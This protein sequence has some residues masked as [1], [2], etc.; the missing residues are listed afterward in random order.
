[1]SAFDEEQAAVDLIVAARERVGQEASAMEVWS[2][3]QHTIGPD[4]AFSLH[5]KCYEMCYEGVADVRPTWVPSEESIGKSNIQKMM[6][7]KGFTTFQEFYD[8]SIGPESRDDFWMSSMENCGIAWEQIPSKAF[9][10]S[11]GGVPNASY[12]PDGRLNIADSCFNKRESF[13]P[14]L[15]YAMESDPR[16]LQ[17]MSFA[18]LDRLSNQI[19]NALHD[20]LGLSPGDAIGICMP[21]TPESI[22]IYLG[23]VKS[24][25]VVISIADSFSAA[26]IAMRCRLGNAKA[27]ITQDVIYRGA[28]FLPLFTRVLEANDIMLSE[29]RE[30]IEAGEPEP[31][32]MKVV[33]LPGMLHAGPYPKLGMMKRSKYRIRYMS[34][35][36]FFLFVF[37]CLC[38]SVCLS[39]PLDLLVHVCI[40]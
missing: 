30:R 17:T 2:V 26:E 14:A 18:V 29:I 9:D 19:A 39:V 28:K 8:W 20:K 1:M 10:L 12:F 27:M 24:G 11:K 35:L 36:S 34:L 13:E 3:L 32:P 5:Q 25:C 4:K 33:I 21:M 38:R 40:L 6:D 31:Q 23:I 15:I 22:A 7:K 16:S 37:V